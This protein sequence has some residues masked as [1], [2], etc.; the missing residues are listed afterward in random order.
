VPP[1]ARVSVEPKWEVVGE[2]EPAAPARSVVEGKWEDIEISFLSDDRVQIRRG[3]KIAETLNYADFGFMDARTE[4]PNQAWEVLRRLA[5]L[6][7]VIGNEAE[8]RVRW[9]KLE[10]RIQEIRAVLRTHF[11]IT[12]DPIPF[13]EENRRLGQKS[14]YHALFKISC[15]RSYRGQDDFSSRQPQFSYRP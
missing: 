9:P 4:N 12:S 5:E 13:A 3:G 6:S 15:A 11:G 8:G 7:G 10:K 2:E 1:A 14:G